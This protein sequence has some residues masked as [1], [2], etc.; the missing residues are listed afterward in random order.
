M[1]QNA[2]FGTIPCGGGGGVANREPGSYIYVCVCHLQILQDSICIYKIKTC[3]RSGILCTKSVMA[4]E[5]Q[6]EKNILKTKE[7]EEGKEQLMQVKHRKKEKKT[8]HERTMKELY[9]AIERKP[10]VTRKD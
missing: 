1:L 4:K 5:P 6:C 9:T 7:N 3:L 10:V 2:G 8:D